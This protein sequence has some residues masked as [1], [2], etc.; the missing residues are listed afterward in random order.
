MMVFVSYDAN[1]RNN[2]LAG[3]YAVSQ[4]ESSGAKR[5]QDTHAHRVWLGACR[6]RGGKK[7]GGVPPF[8]KQLPKPRA[9]CILPVAC[10]L[11]D[12]WPFP[13]LCIARIGGLGFS[14]WF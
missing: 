1:S 10:P 9:L 13:I 2:L 12:L 6:A 5:K 7:R 8:R 3:E 4:E 11:V 14:N